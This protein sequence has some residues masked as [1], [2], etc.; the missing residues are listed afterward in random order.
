MSSTTLAELLLVTRHQIEALF[1]DQNLAD[2]IS[3]DRGLDCILHIGYVDAVA[4]G[5]GASRP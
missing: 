3:A 1:A 4:I 2:R 5:L